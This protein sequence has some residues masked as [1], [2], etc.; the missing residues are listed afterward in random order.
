MQE[1]VADFIL[2]FEGVAKTYP[3][4]QLDATT[5]NQRPET[6][7]Q[8]GFYVQRSGD[9]TVLLNPGWIEFYS[10]TT[11]TTHG[12]PYNYDTHVPL[13]WYGWHIKHGSS[14]LPVNIIDIA[15]TIA[16]LLNISQPNATTGKVITE[17]ITK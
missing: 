15:P 9:I 8:N 4:W 10:S 5:F 6:F 14:A 16:D 3:A 17:M 11:G 1:K 2:G 7:L 12:T 13:L